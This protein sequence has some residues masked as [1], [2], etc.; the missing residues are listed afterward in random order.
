MPRARPPADHPA[1][2]VAYPGSA[3]LLLLPVLHAQRRGIA[4]SETK[5]REA[6]ARKDAAL[7]SVDNFRTTAT[8]PR[9]GNTARTTPSTSSTGAHSGHADAL[10]QTMIGELNDGY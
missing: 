5:R 3:S 8:T 9:P 6:E 4:D 2:R 10:H 1:R 7:N